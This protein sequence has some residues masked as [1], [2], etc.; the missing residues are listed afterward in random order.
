[1]K[2]YYIRHKISVSDTVHLSDSD[3][4]LIIDRKLHKEEEFIELASSNGV[5]LGQITFISPASVEVEVVDKISNITD[6]YEET[7]IQVTV[8]QALSNDAKFHYF[9]EKAVEIGVNEIIPIETEYSLVDKKQAIKKLNTWNK[10]VNEATEQSRNPS[11]P[12]ILKPILI[13]E[14][15][16]K[17]DS[18]EIRIALATEAIDK[19]SIKDV[20]ATDKSGN[21][22]DTGISGS[23]SAEKSSRKYLVA[24]G[25]ERGWSSSDLETLKNKGFVFVFLKG[26]ILRTETASIVI[27]TILKYVNGEL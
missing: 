25:P 4:A 8:A 11:P 17:A 13:D 10:I 20:I 1:M 15:T 16:N 27:T 7:G 26:N 21:S 24:I 19:H 3:S 14:I 12:V 18:S 2:R 9:L 23:K 6:I 5:F 22:R